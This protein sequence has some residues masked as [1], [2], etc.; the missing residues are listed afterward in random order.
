MKTWFPQ[1]STFARK[2]LAAS[3]LF[4]TILSGHTFAQNTTISSL[5]SKLCTATGSNYIYDANLNVFDSLFSNSIDGS[6]ATKL[7]SGGESFCLFRSNQYLTIEARQPIA[8]S[9]TVFFRI[10]NLQAT[11]YKLEFEAENMMRPGLVASLKDKFTGS[12]TFLDMSTTS[13]VNFTV[14]SDAASKAA[15]RFMLVFLRPVSGALP[16][17]F[18]AVSAKKLTTSIQIDWK[19]AQEN[20]VSFYEIEKSTDGR[21][22]F[23]AGSVTTFGNSN[24]EKNYSFID[25]AN[26]AINFYRIKSVDRNGAIRISAIAKLISS[27]SATAITLPSNIIEGNSINLQLSNQPKGKYNVQ[28]FNSGGQLINKQSMQHEG[29]SAL[30]T[31]NITMK[32]ATGNYFVEIVTPTND[33]II[34]QVLIR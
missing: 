13:A 6:D 23:K 8:T 25:I 1:L 12:A 32:P 33:R 19:V 22:F 24:N 27:N 7:F 14:T 17:N 29:G 16:V 28:L 30:L 4:I 5:R 2:S 10:F 20:G 21:N 9:D 18:L 15:D 31:T 3:L 34:K 26:D 11:S